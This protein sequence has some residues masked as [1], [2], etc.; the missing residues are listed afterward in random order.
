MYLQ[1]FLSQQR[2][3]IINHMT[4]RNSFLVKFATAVV[5]RGKAFNV[6]YCYKLFQELR[7]P[8]RRPNRNW[9]RK[10]ILF[11]LWLGPCNVFVNLWKPLPN[12]LVVSQVF[13]AILYLGKDGNQNGIT[14]CEDDTGAGTSLETKI[15]GG[16]ASVTQKEMINKEEERYEEEEE[17]SCPFCR[18]FLDSPC[19][20]S[21][22]A[23]HVCIKV[24]NMLHTPNK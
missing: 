13:F 23:W 14:K 15:N 19:N 4:K 1:R 5:I 17:K 21:F 3:T 24:R 12:V 2:N 22:K 9:Y 20:K 16:S 7:D 11:N 8:K 10:E 6:N 18:F